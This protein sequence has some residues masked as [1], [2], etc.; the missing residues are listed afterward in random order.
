MG[1]SQWRY[2]VVHRDDVGAALRQ[3]RQE[4]YD[5]GEYYRESPDVDLDLTEEEF[6]AGLDPRED[7]DGL[8]EA[9]IEDWRERRRRP[10]P[11]DPDT[12]VAAQPHSGT[13]SIIDMVNGVSHRPGFA[14]VSP[15]TSEELINAF[16]RT[17]PSADQVEEWM[18]AGGSPRERW[19]GSYVISYHDGR[20]GHIHFHGYSGD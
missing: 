19:V 1:A 20:P 2:T 15:L 5:R 16:G 9:I 6:R 10:V 17:T 12:L 14:T 7:D 8:T 4:V 11:V 3:L 13:H 18:K